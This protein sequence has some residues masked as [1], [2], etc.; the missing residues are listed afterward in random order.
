MAGFGKPKQTQEEKLIERMVRHCQKRNPEALD[1]LL[2]SVHL[3]HTPQ[4]IERLSYQLTQG[5]V[6]Q[7]Q[8]DIDTLSWFCGYMASEV[9]SSEDNARHLP[10]AELSKKLILAGMHP[11]QDFAPYPDRRLVVIDIQKA[12]ALPRDLQDELKAAFGSD[13]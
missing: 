1:R 6:A 2:D 13:E 11:F 5:T 12:E 3:D 7:I 9:N 4:E 8:S 10:I